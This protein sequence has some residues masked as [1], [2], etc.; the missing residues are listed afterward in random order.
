VT[1]FA[2][3]YGDKVLARLKSAAGSGGFGEVLRVAPQPNPKDLRAEERRNAPRDDGALPEDN[4][5]PPIDDVDAADDIIDE[6]ADEI[7]VADDDVVDDGA[8]DDGAVDGGGAQRERREVAVYTGPVG[9]SPGVSFVGVGPRNELVDRARDDG[10]D[11]L[12][13]LEVSSLLIPSNGV[14]NTSIV[15][16]AVEPKSGAMLRK[17]REVNN[18]AYFVSKQKPGAKDPVD[19]MVDDFFQ[20]V[21]DNLYLQ[22]MPPLT[23]ANVEGRIAAVTSQSQPEPL[24][25]LAELLYYRNQ[26]LA[27]NEQLI[28]AYGALL[29]SPEDGQRLVSGQPAEKKKVLE[30][31]LNRTVDTGPAPGEVDFFGS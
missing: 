31:L 1:Y 7:D 8:V 13:I 9:L 5:D 11:V 27:T 21:V 3:S 20:Y 12:L 29:E 4:V 30:G 6:P 22:P 19:D 18:L 17:S 10:A 15:M 28:A 16:E 23:P 26:D 14:L 2:G 25:L 24:K